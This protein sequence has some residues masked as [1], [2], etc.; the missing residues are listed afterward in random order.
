V[1]DRK[2]ADEILAA[3]DRTLA[4][5]GLDELLPMPAWVLDQTR[6][7]AAAQMP[8]VDEAHV[9]TLLGGLFMAN[10]AACNYADLP[11]TLYARRY[12]Q[13]LRYIIEAVLSLLDDPPA[14]PLGAEPVFASWDELLSQANEWDKSRE[15]PE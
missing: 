6:A 9:M 10:S 14:F 1:V 12:F 8:V 13:G 5:M 7:L 2:E 11:N 4:N 15:R 3:L